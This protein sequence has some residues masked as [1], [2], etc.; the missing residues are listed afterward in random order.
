MKKL[1]PFSKRNGKRLVYMHPAHGIANEPACRS[2][3]WNPFRGLS[4]LWPRGVLAMEHA[5]DYSAQKPEAPGKY[6]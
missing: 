5:A 2:R 4:G 6:K 1:A 3:G